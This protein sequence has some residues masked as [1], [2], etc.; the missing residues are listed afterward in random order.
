MKVPVATPGTFHHCVSRIWDAEFLLGEEEKDYLVK[1]MWEYEEFCGV[2]VLTY[3][4]MSDHFHV[5]LE[6]P[7]RPP[8]GL[9]DQEVITRL[10]RLP[11][12]NR[13]DVIEQQ[14]AEMRQRG[15]T[16]AAEA[17][18]QQVGE[19]MFD[20]SS[21]IGQVKQRFSMWYNPAHKRLG[22][23]WEQRFKSVLVEG[24]GL[25]LGVMAAYVD[26]NPVRAGLVD[27]PKDYRWCGYGD[28]MSGG[29]KARKGLR[30]IMAGALGEA[31]TFQAAVAG[32]QEWLFGSKTRDGG[33]ASA[34]R[35]VQPGISAAEA[36]EWEKEKRRLPI[37]DYLRMRVRYFSDGVALGSREFVEG[38]FAAYRDRFSTKR[39]NGARHLRLVDSEELYALRDLQVRLFGKP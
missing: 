22:T 27:D 15:D 31:V 36:A 29:A 13:A 8:E 6:V 20:L 24:T 1:L 33:E 26:L 12:I 21:F 2:N 38:V 9:S 5:L 4:I 25:A 11:G 39:K 23:L 3:C 16:E 17:L 19:R 14:L 18:K 34:A 37:A 32:Y 10:R 7:A 28:A 30:M 35:R